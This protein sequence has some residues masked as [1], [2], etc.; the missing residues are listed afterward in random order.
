[1]N[2]FSF[3]G[4]NIN[5]LTFKFTNNTI[6]I[7]HT[8]NADVAIVHVHRPVRSIYIHETL[9]IVRSIL[10]LSEHLLHVQVPIFHYVSLTKSS[11][12]CIH[13]PVYPVIFNL[14]P[15]P[16]TKWPPTKD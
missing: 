14:P 3:A 15:P 2:Y 7:C 10:I 5:S 6:H 1:M 11:K 9:R 8:A 4:R 13:T 16:P 12:I